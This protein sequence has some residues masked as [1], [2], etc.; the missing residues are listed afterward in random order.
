MEERRVMC[1]KHK[2]INYTEEL[3]LELSGSEVGE[4]RRRYIQKPGH[5]I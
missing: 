2:H 3:R 4:E 1:Q 5:Q